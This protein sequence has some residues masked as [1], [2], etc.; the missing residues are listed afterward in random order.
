MLWYNTND[1]TKACDAE[2]DNKNGALVD[3]DIKMFGHSGMYLRYLSEN[4]TLKLEKPN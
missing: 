2:P 3:K 1:Q 4:N